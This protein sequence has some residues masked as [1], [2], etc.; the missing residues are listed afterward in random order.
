MPFSWQESL[1]DNGG[2][3]EAE[4]IQEIRDVLDTTHNA[5]LANNHAYE[6]TWYS[7]HLTANNDTFYGAH[8]G[9]YFGTNRGAQ[10]NNDYIYRGSNRNHNDW[11][12]ASGGF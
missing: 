7:N 11:Y 8:E 12:C 3:V 9:T 5:A 6:S 2:I 4:E 10:C 1:T